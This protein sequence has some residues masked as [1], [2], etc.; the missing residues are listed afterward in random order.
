MTTKIYGI[1]NCSSMKKAFD[2]FDTH[3]IDYEFH[4]FKREGLAAERLDDWIKNAQGEPL[5]NRRG[6]LWRRLSP[7]DQQAAQS[8]PDAARAIM[9]NTPNI[10]KRP[11]IVFD[12]GTTIVGVN[13]ARWTQELGLLTDHA[14]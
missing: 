10:I 2:W 9:L 6:Q 8:S 13:E 12:N 11:I 5:L 1:R 4:D 3:G 14:E 7:A